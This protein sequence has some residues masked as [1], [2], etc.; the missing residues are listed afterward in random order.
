MPQGPAAIC[1]DVPRSIDVVLT[2][3]SPLLRTSV[4]LTCFSQAQSCLFPRPRLRTHCPVLLE[5]PLAAP[6]AFASS[7]QKVIHCTDLFSTSAACLPPSCRLSES[8]RSHYH[9][10]TRSQ[11][12][13][14]NLS[15]AAVVLPPSGYRFLRSAGP[16]GLYPTGRDDH[17]LPSDIHPF[18]RF[19]LTHPTRYLFLFL[20]PPPPPCLPGPRRALGCPFPYPRSPIIHVL[21]RQGNTDKLPLPNLSLRPGVGFS[22]QALSS[23][24]HCYARQ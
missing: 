17:W 5:D 16:S 3:G 18:P 19:H 21:A 20:P 13:T 1:W 24:P 6:F 23:L 22:V 10:A 2:A 14:I 12:L 11:N 8:E 9:I 4:C 7:Q 15:A